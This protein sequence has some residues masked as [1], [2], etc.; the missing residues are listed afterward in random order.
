MKKM[1]KIKSDMKEL[2]RE[3]KE[4]KCPRRKKRTMIIRNESLKKLK[5][6][7]GVR[8]AKKKTKLEGKRG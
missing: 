8:R 2:L 5:S 4:Q 1:K 3:L 6:V 7:W